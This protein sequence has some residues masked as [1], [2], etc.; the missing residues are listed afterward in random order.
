MVKKVKKAQEVEKAVEILK[1]KNFLS[2]KYMKWEVRQFNII[3]GDMA[4]GKS[5]CIKIM[6]FFEDI[7]PNL[8]IA[9][10]D[11]FIKNLEKDYLFNYLADKFAE[12]FYISPLE[13]NRPPFKINYTFSFGE[14]KFDI[15]IKGSDIADVTVESASL[16]SLLKEWLNY[17]KKRAINVPE[18]VTYDGF[19]EMKHYFYNN[20]Q[21][22]FDGCFPVKAAFIPASRA[23][24]TLSTDYTDYY[25]R[26]YNAFT[27]NLRLRKCK[28]QE[29][30]EKILK[31]NINIEDTIYLDSADGRRVPLAKAS[32]GQQEI[33]Y[34][35]MHL[36]RL[37]NY[38]YTYSKSQSLFIEEPSAYLS[39]Q[40]EKQLIEFIVEIYNRQKN[41]EIPIRFF[42][43][44]YSLYIINSL[45][46]MLKKG[47]LIENYNEQMDKINRRMKIP[48]L[49]AD[50]VSAYYINNKGEGK[51]ILFKNQIQANE[52]TKVSDTIKKNDMELSELNDELSRLP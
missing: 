12:I 34:F 15:T 13:K 49:R 4:A 10:Y 25:L 39:P 11:H 28:N 30:V 50:D 51:S 31:A 14:S 29:A 27:D 8:L 32:S 18:K 3:S 46:N 38:S 2:I 40:D 16:E 48:P 52:I 47:D 33:A 9:P 36:D 42:I 1:I 45:N 7:I 37:G 17:S 22:K 35:L 23:A 20:L 41:T 43:T 5:L 21:K 26:K 44:T 6:N 19:I 24:L